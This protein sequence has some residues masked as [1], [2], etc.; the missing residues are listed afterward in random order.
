MGAENIRAAVVGA[1]IGGLCAALELAASGARVTIFERADYPGGRM[2]EIRAGAGAVDAG[3]T[4]L[5][6]RWI[7]ED[8]FARTGPSL[9]SVLETDALEVLARHAW[10]GPATLDLYSDVARSTDAIGEFAGPDEARG[11][12]AFAERARRAY[13]LLDPI[14]LQKPTPSL[15]GLMAFP[16]PSRLLTLWRS[17]P[18]STLWK[19]VGTHFRDPR[20]QQLFARYATYCGSSPFLAPATLMLIAHVEQLGVWSVRGGMQRLAE[21]LAARVHSCG[22][23]LEFGK[24]VRRVRVERGRVHSLE[25]ADGRS[26]GF[27]LV[28]ANTEPWAVAAGYLGEDVRTACGAATSPRPSLSAVT[29][30]CRA[31]VDGWPLARH[32]VFFSD[33]Y[34]TEFATLQ[35]GR[36]PTDPT[37][38]L[39][40]QDRP[41]PEHALTDD[42]ERVFMLMNAPARS[43]PAAAP[44]ALET[45][46]MRR[47]A[48]AGITLT[49]DPETLVRTTPEDF[50]AR[51]PGSGGALYGMATHGWRAAFARRGASTR[52]RGFYLAGG[53]VH[54]GAG[55]PMAAL[56]G[57]YAAAQALSEVGHGASLSVNLPRT[58]RAVTTS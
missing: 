50:A 35:G 52:V 17:G 15:T 10:A 27:D 3:P 8:I 54:P 7:F 12:R 11:Y 41:T 56:S 44:A 33:D 38:Y 9:E 26:E 32:N 1:G 6:M 46:A 49:P 31:R 51:F 13:E 30:T 22:G 21:A 57:R 28:I 42:S 48:R 45:V 43:A 5:T 53:G 19:A 4:V 36:Y 23:Q 55:V 40:A 34:P 24:E 16:S 20:L 37:I 39:C 47:L 25:L 29:W 58:R 14:F 18:F 2:R